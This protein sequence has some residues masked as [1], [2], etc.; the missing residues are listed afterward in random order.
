M[1]LLRLEWQATRRPAIWVF[2]MEF[3]S[4]GR[5]AF[6]FNHLSMSS[7]QQLCFHRIYYQWYLICKFLKF[8]LWFI[9]ILF[10]NFF[11]KQSENRKY[12]VDCRID[13]GLRNLCFLLLSLG[14]GLRTTK[15]NLSVTDIYIINEIK[16][17]ET[18]NLRKKQ[19]SEITVTKE[20]NSNYYYGTGYSSSIYVFI[21]YW[22]KKMYC[23]IINPLWSFYR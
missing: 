15:I 6:A 5:T 10:V 22:D 9:D 21:K 12:F 2:G 1:D 13:N 17:W 4:S 3:E 23:N 14:Q 11:Q 18:R 7:T 16:I 8:I 20:G 19:W